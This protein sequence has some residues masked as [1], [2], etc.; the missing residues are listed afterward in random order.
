MTGR[1]K[2]K[3]VEKDEEVEEVDVK[4]KRTYKRKT[5]V[6]PADFVA[7][8]EKIAII[9]Q[10]LYSDVIWDEIVKIEYLDD[11]KEFVYDFTVPGNDS[12]MVDCGVLVHNT[13][14]SVEYNTDMLF[15]IDGEL[16]KKKIGE[17]IEKH[18]EALGA[19]EEGKSLIESHPNDTWLG[20]IKNKHVEV[21]SCDENG[22]VSWKTVEAVTKHPVVNEDGSSKLLKVSLKSGREVTATKGKS[23]IMRVDNKIVPIEGK[24][25]KEGDRVPV[26]RVL[27]V[28][29]EITN[30]NGL[31]TLDESFGY[32]VGVYLSKGTTTHDNIFMM[33]ENFGELPYMNIPVEMLDA[34]KPFLK[35]LIGGYFT[36]N[37]SISSDGIYAES[38]SITLLESIQQVL[39]RFDIMSEIHKNYNQSYTLLITSGNAH[40]FAQEFKLSIKDKQDR[41]NKIIAE[42]TPR[43]T[44]GMNDVIAVK[45]SNGQA[46]DVHRDD[47][48]DLLK[49]TTDT[50]DIQ[51]LLAAKDEDIIY[52]E[53]VKI[54]E[55][56]NDYPYVY[57]LTVKDT[58]T[59][60]TFTGIAMYDTFHMA[61]VSA[62]SKAVRGVPR[63]NELLSVSKNIKAPIMKI[64]INEEYR[65]NRVRCLK[66]MND[67]RTV[68]FKDIAKASR[69]YYDPND[70]DSRIPEDKPFLELYKEFNVGAPPTTPWVLR[71]ELDKA[72]M[73]EYSVDMITLHNII[74]SKFEEHIS[75]MYT[76]DNADKLVMR[77]KLNLKED[78]EP[79][80]ML[81][82]L[83][84]LEHSILETVKINGVKGI[85]RASLV[86]T[87][88]NKNTRRTLYSRI[89]KKFE[90]IEEYFVYTD[91]S[92]MRDVLALPFV[93]P[94]CTITN[95]INEIYEVLGVEAAR[96]MLYNEIVD[97]LDNITVN[98]RHIA[99]LVDVMTNKGNIISVNRHGINRGDIGPLAKCSFEETTEKLI[100]AGVFAEF[101][102]INGVAANIML[103][104]VAPAGTG[105]V[106]I[107][108]DEGKLGKLAK[109]KNAQ[110]LSIA[111]DDDEELE[112]LCDK[113]TLDIKLPVPALETLFVPKQS[114]NVVII[115]MDDEEPKKSKTKKNKK[116]E[117]SDED[118]VVEEEKPKKVKKTVK[119]KKVVKKT[120]KTKKVVVEP[121][122]SD[123]EDEV[124]EEKPKKVKTTVKT[125][126]VVV[127]PEP[128][129]DD[130]VVE[131]E[132]PKKVKKTVKTKKVVVEPEPSDDDDEVVGRKAQEGQEDRKDQEGCCRA[133]TI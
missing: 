101:D 94:T 33:R 79:D 126:K 51:V 125:K 85:E 22:K 1:R 80:D 83:K 15:K 7:V 17:F 59:F 49:T 39:V 128:S 107:L 2:N 67:I 105:D 64:H 100:K 91:G 53:I 95:D 73:N 56:D 109:I 25:I 11:P 87:G 72:K 8:R 89:L 41:L 48:D 117:P 23:F 34:N 46:Q 119:T 32:T 35:A 62:A 129:D 124:V 52:D 37:A 50:Q 99:L 71:L 81:T 16:H 68:R 116:A 122:P 121:E 55:V 21:Q 44:Y 14:N 24:Y 96:Q 86:F 115:G 65:G 102:K 57:D 133:R 43:Y 120:V 113:A 45:L 112:Q 123:D 111:E 27:H 61:G 70:F 103:G 5:A 66:F 63:L 40:R 31:V 92:N 3:G 12:F 118:E 30:I 75:C 26:S 77:I 10:A 42:H 90:D 131:E 106:D 38:T 110:L 6:P 36:W 69:I 20:W 9:K 84:A 98:F 114:N 82:E 18:I 127:E 28:N 132:K 88:T 108:I 78:V 13:L 74:D 76:D 104:Q 60:N 47:I 130:E 29:N 97:V 54:E 93:D 4:P 58:R 19:S